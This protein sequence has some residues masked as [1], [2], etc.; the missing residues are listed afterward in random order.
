[1]GE[2]LLIMYCIFIIGTFIYTVKHIDYLLFT[3]EDFRKIKR[4]ITLED[5][6][7]TII[8][9]VYD[10]LLFI[11]GFFRWIFHKKGE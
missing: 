7:F 11:Y 6:V 9:F 5:W 8:F 2:T 10:P 3:L 4:F 1:M